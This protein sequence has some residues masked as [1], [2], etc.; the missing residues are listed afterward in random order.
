MLSK[1]A[2]VAAE[3]AVTKVVFI[4]LTQVAWVAPLILPNL[5][6]P[7]TGRPIFVRKAQD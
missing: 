5:G 2:M 1:A 4:A 3:A 7:D 6:P